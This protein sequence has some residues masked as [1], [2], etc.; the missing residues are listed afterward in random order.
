[1]AKVFLIYRLKDGVRREDFESWVRTTDYP[2]MR[3]VGTVGAFHTY[4]TTENF[5][6]GSTPAYDYVE[7]FDVPDIDAF[8]SRDFPG[9]V[10]QGVLG[11]FLGFA[12]DPKIIVA[13]EVA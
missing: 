11:E 12:E 1:M 7:V 3:S 5:L 2:K 8:R 10:V 13:E 6:D 4:R 9:E